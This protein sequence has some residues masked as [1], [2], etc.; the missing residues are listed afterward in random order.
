MGMYRLTIARR[1]SADVVPIDPQIRQ[2]FDDWTSRRAFVRTRW[3]RDKR[4]PAGAWI[5]ERKAVYVYFVRGA[6]GRP[7]V[8][9]WGATVRRWY[10]DPSAFHNAAM[11]SRFDTVVTTVRELAHAGDRDAGR[12]LRRLE[13]KGR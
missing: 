6:D 3:V 13:R 1:K 5:D 12:V 9:P 8:A 11:L 10:P 7:R 2:A 4:T